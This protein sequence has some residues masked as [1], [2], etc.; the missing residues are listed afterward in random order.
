MNWRTSVVPSARLHL[1]QVC[2]IGM[3]L[4]GVLMLYRQNRAKE[5][6]GRVVWTSRAWKA[7][8][9]RIWPLC[10]SYSASVP[11]MLQQNHS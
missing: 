8:V 4:S 9:I 7:L 11:Q 3:E 2:S 10:C 5:Q 6:G 1:G